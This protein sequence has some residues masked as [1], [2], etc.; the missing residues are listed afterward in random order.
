ML[1]TIQAVRSLLNNLYCGRSDNGIKKIE[2]DL[3][4]GRLDSLLQ[5]VSLQDASEILDDEESLTVD[6]GTEEVKSSLPTSESQE[7]AAINE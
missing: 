4:E 5:N 2:S 6:E 1:F 3:T 7:F